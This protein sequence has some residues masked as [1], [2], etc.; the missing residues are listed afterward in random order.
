[1]ENKK[2]KNGWGGARPGAG[3]PFLDGKSRA[4]YKSILITKEAWECMQGVRNKCRYIS[5]LIINEIGK[6]AEKTKNQDEKRDV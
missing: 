6:S 4:K 2:K 5:G 1:M 3:R